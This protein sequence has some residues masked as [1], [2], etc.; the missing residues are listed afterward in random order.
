MSKPFFIAWSLLWSLCFSLKTEKNFVLDRITYAIKRQPRFECS[1]RPSK[2][3]FIFFIYPPFIKFFNLA[4]KPH[5]W[6]S[7]YRLRNITSLPHSPKLGSS[8]TQFFDHIVNFQEFLFFCRH[9]LIGF[10]VHGTT[11][12]QRVVTHTATL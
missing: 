7:N 8:H 3:S 12:L 10:N 5:L 6:V 9:I 4:C 1:S 2:C 11:Q